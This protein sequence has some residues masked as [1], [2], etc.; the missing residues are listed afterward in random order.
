MKQV[1]SHIIY[2]DKTKHLR[3]NK[4]ALSNLNKEDIL[5]YAYKE[6]TNNDFYSIRSENKKYK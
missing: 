5:D 3:R 6:S 2:E 4:Y 1:R